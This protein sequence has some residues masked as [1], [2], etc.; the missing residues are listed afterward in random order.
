MNG[1]S[2]F[3]AKNPKL[4]EKKVLLLDGAPKFKGYNANKFSNRVYSIN[5]NTVN[6]MKEIGAWETIK[7]IRCR[8]VKQMQVRLCNNLKGFAKN[9]ERKNTSN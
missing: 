8:P 2:K 9:C 6:L 3:L 5:Q 1:L 4:C 7:S